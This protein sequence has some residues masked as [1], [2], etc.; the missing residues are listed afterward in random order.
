MEN[1]QQQNINNMKRE[2]STRAFILGGLFGFGLTQI[3]LE[4]LYKRN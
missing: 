4:I 1:R 2:K 3:I